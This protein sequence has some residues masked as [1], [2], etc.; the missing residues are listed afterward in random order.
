VGDA[1][2]FIRANS[3]ASSD[4]R[5][6]TATVALFATA[7][8]AIS[9]SDVLPA[10]FAGSAE[11]AHLSRGQA[12]AFLLNIALL[13]FAWRRSN[14]LMRSFA[15]RDAAEQRAR[16]LAYLDEVTGLYNRRYMR[17]NFER[18]HAE[19][20]TKSVLLVIDLDHFKKVND[21]YGHEV[22]DELLVISAQRLR[23]CCPDDACCIRL[24]GDEFAVLLL[25]VSKYKPGSKALAAKLIEQLKEPVRLANTDICIGASIGISGSERD[26]PD[27][28]SILRRADLAMYEAKRMG[29][30]RCVTFDTTME[31]ELNR[32][33]ALEAEMREGIQ[34]NQFVPYF[35]PIIDLASKEIHGFEVLARWEHPTRGLIEPPEFLEIAEASGL[36]G[37][38]SLAV[39]RDA[40]AIAASWPSRF[41][42]SVNVSPIQFKDPLLAQRIFKLLS[43]TGFPPGRL[44][45]EVPESTLIADRAFALATIQ[46]LKNSGIGIVVDDFGTGY[47]ALTRLQSLPFDR[48]KIDRSFVDS[49][50]EGE[51]AHAIV[52][53]IATLGKGLSIPVAAE[54]VESEAI[55][56]KLVELGCDDAQGWLFAKALSAEEINRTLLGG[57]DE[58]D[59]APAR[60]ARRGRRAPASKLTM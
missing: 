35:Q 60:A 36:I 37:D 57:S 44:D 19:A 22:G 42:I 55:Q 50:Q 46:S 27:L 54:G 34:Q 11:A 52:Q 49:L 38:L 29:G 8:F 48:L 32:R 23:S 45:L 58:D 21:L 17:E 43:V 56:A 20:E 7:V 51:G 12:T 25:D 28:S 6:I 14:Q 3:S 59:E 26:H 4:T 13:L 24:G 1:A 31:A 40:L 9:G 18:H 47:A 16:D 33:T 10:V 5:W 2:P 53:A 30:N 39:M 15:E 41:R